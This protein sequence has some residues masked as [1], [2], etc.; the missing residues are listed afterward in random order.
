MYKN[1]LFVILGLLI[2][3]KGTDSSSVVTA[4]FES[5]PIKQ[6]TTVSTGAEQLPIYI[7]QLKE[8]RV[9]VV[10]N[11]ASLVGDKHL[12]DTLLQ[13]QV[14]V[15]KIFVP[16]HGFRGKADAGA[17]IDDS[18]DGKTGLPVIS[19]YGQQKKRPCSILVPRITKYV[20]LIYSRLHRISW[21]IC[22]G[23]E[24][25]REELETLINLTSTSA[26]IEANL[27]FFADMKSFDFDTTSLTTIDRWCIADIAPMNDVKQGKKVTYSPCKMS[28]IEP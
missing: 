24:C 8:K 11:H 23:S 14:N 6:T 21:P 7:P 12:L 15:E 22:D 25:R 17:E 28:T 3:C 5:D 9:G 16:E 13:L 18:T 26:C 20:K 2:S 19:L 27:T 4:S 1:W 10:I